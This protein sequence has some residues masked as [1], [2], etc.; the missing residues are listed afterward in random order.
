[1]KVRELTADDG[2][3]WYAMRCALWPGADDEHAD[4]VR[5]FF[6]GELREPPAVLVAE[7]DGR[8]VGFVELSIRG[9]AEGCRTEQVG[10]VEGWYVAPDARGRGV[11]RALI[12]AGER[13]ARS[14]G[15]SE[16]GSDAEIDNHAGDAA[17]RA[18]GFETAGVIR[19]YRKEL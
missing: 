13:W 9:Y 10:Y 19:C 6:A 7:R 18:C 16:M 11:G 8:P 5:R 12:E 4:T 14:R 15:C 2:E 17:H 1:M 3:R